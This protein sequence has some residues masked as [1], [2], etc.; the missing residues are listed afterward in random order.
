MSHFLKIVQPLLTKCYQVL[1][2][3]PSSLGNGQILFLFLFF[4][5]RTLSFGGSI[6]VMFVLCFIPKAGN[7]EQGLGDIEGLPA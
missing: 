4:L 5:E 2:M 1:D 3:F 7:L 6:K